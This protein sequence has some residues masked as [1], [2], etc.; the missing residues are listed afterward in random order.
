MK[1]EPQ[2]PAFHDRV[3]VRLINEEERERFDEMLEQE[4]YL[5]SAKL[6]GRTMRYVAEVE[7]QWVALIAF[8]GAAP[9]LEGEGKVDGL[10]SAAT[11]AAV[12]LRGQQQPVFIARGAG[13]PPQSGLQ[14]AGTLSAASE[15]R[16]AA[17]VGECGSG[18][19]KFC[20]RKPV[21]RHLLSG[22]RV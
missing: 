17:T 1:K 22:L 11:G 16:L 21:Q 6:G 4:H 2:D 3:Q 18:G 20:G 9:H 15:R 14:S 7:G 5:H 19:G 10:E 13:A 8:S 12:G